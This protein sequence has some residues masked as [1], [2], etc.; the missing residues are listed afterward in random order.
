MV[1]PDQRPIG[2][3]ATRLVIAYHAVSWLYPLIVVV[4]IALSDP[5]GSHWQGHDGPLI[6][7]DAGKAGSRW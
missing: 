4:V 5:L 2:S 1:N 6:A 7:P 3:R